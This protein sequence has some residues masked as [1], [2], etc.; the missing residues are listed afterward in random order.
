ME[1][2]NVDRRV[3]KTIDAIMGALETLLQD[4]GIEQ[5][6]V[7]RIAEKADIG[8]TTFFRHYASKEEA[9]SDLVRRE[10]A[11][12]IDQTLPLLRSV[13][14][15]AACLALCKHVDD[16]RQIWSAILSGGAADRLC[17][18]LLESTIQH[19]AEWPRRR[20]WLEDPEATAL[21]VTLIVETLGW[22][23]TRSPNMIPER[24]AEIIDRLFVAPLT[25][26]AC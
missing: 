14:G 2:K 5:I 11:I 18:A 16:R 4:V 1:T 17:E 26:E 3:R 15:R 10:A 13:D 21:I 25:A 22:W 9:V 8:Y 24:V 19:S 12:L 20:S 6:T 23:L 7:K